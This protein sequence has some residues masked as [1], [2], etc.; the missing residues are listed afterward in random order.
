MDHDQN[1]LPGTKHLLAESEKVTFGSAV[2][3]AEQI[4]LAFENKPNRMQVTFV[5]GDGD[6]RFVRYGETKDLLGNSA[7]ARGIRYDREQMCNA[8]AN[9]S[10]G[11]RDPGWIF[12]TVL[13][14]LNPAVRNYY[15]VNKSDKR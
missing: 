5:A 8:P 3:K 4:H 6:E 13:K 11:W 1:P 2:D 7:A 10:I 15:Q 9:S 14:N 12:H